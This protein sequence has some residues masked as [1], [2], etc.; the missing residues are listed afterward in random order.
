LIPSHKGINCNTVVDHEA[1]DTLDDPIFNSSIPYTV[2]RPFVMTYIL[3]H[4]QDSLD[5]PI[6]N[7]LHEINSLV[8]NTLISYYVQ[9]RKEQVVLVRLR[10]GHGRLS[11]SHSLNNEEQPECIPII[12]NY[13][14][15]HILID[16]MNV[17]DVCQTSYNVNTLFVYNCHRRHNL[18]Q[19]SAGR[20]SDTLS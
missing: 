9:N 15:K 6:D 1:K 13:S 14:L 12:H 4:W 19:Q 8:G 5:K 20:Q 18:K 16:C 10:I 17:V 2:L 3:K 11:H 7:K